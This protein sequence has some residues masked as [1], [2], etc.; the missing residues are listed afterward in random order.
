MNSSQTSLRNFRNL[1]AIQLLLISIVLAFAS[2]KDTSDSAGVDE[3]KD[4]DSVQPEIAAQPYGF[5]HLKL[6]SAVLVDSFF[7]KA[8]ADPDARFRKILFNIKVNNYDDFPGTL[9]LAGFM[10]KRNDDYIDCGGPEI[11]GILDSVETLENVLLA[12]LEL[13]KA[14]IRILVGQQGQGRRYDYLLF[15][16]FIKD[17]CNHKTLAYAVTAYPKLP[18]GSSPTVYTNPCPPYKP[19]D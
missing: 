1:R 15:V 14:K 13:S 16:P 5:H 11:L 12:N 7:K 18:G 6:D 19:N 2:C 3:K 9:T 4:A 8:A 17:S 10:A